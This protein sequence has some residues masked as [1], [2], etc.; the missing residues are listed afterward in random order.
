MRFLIVMSIILM[1]MQ[2]GPSLRE[3]EAIAQLACNVIGESRVFESSFRIKEINAVREEIG[4]PAFLGSDEDIIESLEYGLCK[5]LVLN[6][7]DYR[8]KMTD[9][10]IRSLEILTD[11]RRIREERERE[12]EL[13]IMEEERIPRQNWRQ[14]IEAY[15]LTFQPRVSLAI[16]EKTGNTTE[17]IEINYSCKKD[18][19]YRLTIKIRDY[20]DTLS[21]SGYCLEEESNTAHI[22]VHN[23]DILLRDM[24]EEMATSQNRRTGSFSFYEYFD[25]LNLVEEVRMIIHGVDYDPDEKSIDPRRYPPLD[26]DSKLNEPI[27]L[28]VGLQ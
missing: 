21:E 10:I 14:A 27:V 16:Y 17:S 23:D 7:P 26:S 9:S 8:E 19:D 4:E 12:E 3:K 13:A 24:L 18:M 15:I 25:V 28:S 1:L 22:Y 11:L 2:C 6:D 20:P 5:E